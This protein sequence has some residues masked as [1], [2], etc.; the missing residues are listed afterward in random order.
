MG[1]GITTILCKANPEA[2]YL[3][4]FGGEM[5]IMSSTKDRLVEGVEEHDTDIWGDTIQ[6]LNRNLTTKRCCRHMVKDVT[7][8]LESEQ[9]AM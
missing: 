8:I 5:L 9:Q 4:T 6:D 2:C 7:Y 1:E 3:F